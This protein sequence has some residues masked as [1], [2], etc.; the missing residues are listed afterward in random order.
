MDPQ[1]NLR[2]SY[3]ILNFIIDQLGSEHCYNELKAFS[4]TCQML[5]H[6]CRVYLFSTINLHDLN[7]TAQFAALL[8]EN[9]KIAGYVQVLTCRVFTMSEDLANALLQLNNLQTLNLYGQHPYDWNSL[10][11]RMQL[12]LT[13]LFSSPSLSSLFVHRLRLP[14]SLLSGCP[15]LKH[16]ALGAF[17]SIIPEACDNTLTSPPQLLSLDL[18]NH[19]AG[20]TEEIYNMRRANGLLIVD[21]SNLQSFISS[22]HRDEQE[23]HLEKILRLTPKLNSLEFSGIL[24][25]LHIP[26]SHD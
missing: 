21:L 12:A 19:V 18:S 16:L 11:S 3:D 14:A 17:H 15:S 24:G 25:Y 26:Y 2:I 1:S 4:Q 7:S 5:L 13:Q 8:E 20:T 22:V 23:K 9:C 6:P 10:S